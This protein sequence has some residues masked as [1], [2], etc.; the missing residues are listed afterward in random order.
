LIAEALAANDAF[1]PLR[2]GVAR[3]RALETDLSTCLPGYMRE[4]VAAAGVQD[5]ILTLLTPHSALAA[6]LR[7]LEPKVVGVMRER[8]WAVDSVKVRIRP[9]AETPPPAP[10]QARIS[11]AGL[12]CLDALR[13]GLEPSELRDAL[14]RMVARHKG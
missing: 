7:H 4:N 13:A 6:R 3:L 1:A 2:E 12:A 10:K 5:G 11:Q 9:I 14:E 8:G